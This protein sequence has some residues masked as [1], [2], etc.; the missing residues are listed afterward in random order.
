MKTR[1]LE[2]TARVVRE[3]RTA[4]ILNLGCGPAREV[5]EF[6]AEHPL[7]GRAD[8]TFLDF[9][10][11]TLNFVNTT[12]GKLKAVHHC[13]AV[14]RTRKMSVTQ[15]IKYMARPADSPLGSGFDF[16]YCGGL[17]D[18]LSNQM[19]QQLTSLF[20]EWL[21]PGGLV[22]VANMNARHRPFRHMVEFLLD[23]HLLYRSRDE[24]AAFAPEKAHPDDWRVLMEPV[25]VNLFLEVRKP[26][27][28]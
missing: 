27:T 25:S 7:A 9:D 4:R 2:E 3:G 19:C 22:L 5:Q 26:R 15:L 8:F 17:F 1:L 10:E 12:L 18:Y 24:M 6:I 20:Y 28:G 21:A 23:W 14:I 11:E 13:P 16:I